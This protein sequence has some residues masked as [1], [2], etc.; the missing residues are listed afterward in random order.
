MIASRECLFASCP[1]DTVPARTPQRRHRRQKSDARHP[2]GK[3]LLAGEAAG[4]VSINP[5]D[6]DV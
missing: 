1:E 2:A 5:A 4:V 3:S 6:E